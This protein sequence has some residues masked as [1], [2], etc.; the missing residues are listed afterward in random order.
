LASG[1]VTDDE[2]RDVLQRAVPLVPAGT[3]LTRDGSWLRSAL[4]QIARGET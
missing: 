2:A 1:C 4:E 3:A